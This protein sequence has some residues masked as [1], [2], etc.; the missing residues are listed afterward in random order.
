MRTIDS[1]WT[2][3]PPPSQGWYWN[4]NG[5][6]DSAPHVFFVM[7]SGSTH[8]TFIPMNQTYNGLPID[9]DE[10]GGW[11]LPLPVPEVPEI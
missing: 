9:T 7:W 1:N 3:T 2:Q 10:Y 5:D 6:E 8:K 11:W 4:W